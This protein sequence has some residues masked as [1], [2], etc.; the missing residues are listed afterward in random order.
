VG[1][2]FVGIGGGAVL[3]TSLGFGFRGELEISQSFPYS[4]TVVRAALGVQAGL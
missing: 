2:G 1:D 3:K 4:A